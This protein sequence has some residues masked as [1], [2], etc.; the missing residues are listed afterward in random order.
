MAVQFNGTGTRLQ[1]RVLDI[2]MSKIVCTGFSGCSFGVCDRS[3]TGSNGTAVMGPLPAPRRSALLQF[4][5]ALFPIDRRALS[6]EGERNLVKSPG[7]VRAPSAPVT[8][9]YLLLLA[10][11]TS[12]PRLLHPATTRQGE[13]ARRVLL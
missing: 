1:G 10:G 4:C 3:L 8:D 12:A 13:L 7:P 2:A 6:R 5:P 11:A 9:P